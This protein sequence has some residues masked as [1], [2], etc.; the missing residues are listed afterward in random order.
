MVEDSL[1]MNL[2]RRSSTMSKVG[3]SD[4]KDGYEVQVV[5]IKKQVQLIIERLSEGVHV[6]GFDYCENTFVGWVIESI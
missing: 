2:I 5:G 6:N 4:W 3:K 1:R